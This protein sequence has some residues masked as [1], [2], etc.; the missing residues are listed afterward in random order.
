[1]Y[2]YKRVVKIMRVIK[3]LME[4]RKF[5]LNLILCLFLAKLIT[6]YILIDGGIRDFF[7]L[8]ITSVIFIA[9]FIGFALSKF[10]HKNKMF[11]L[12]YIGLSVLMLADSMYYNYYHQ[13]VS[14]KQLWQIKNV[15]S[16]PE[17][18]FA[19][20]IPLSVFLLIDIPFIYDFFKKFVEKHSK[21]IKEIIYKNIKSRKSIKRMNI[22][23]ALVFLI[24]VVNPLNS[25]LI[26][27]I[28]SVEFFANH[29]KDVYM[30]LTD[31]MISETISAE[32]VL[33][34]VEVIQQDEVSNTLKYHGIGEGK[35]L[36]MVQ[37]E[38]L[39]NFVIGRDY[40]GHT[41][42]PN[43]NKLIEEDSLYF[44]SY[45]SHIGKGN[46]A[47]AEF[48]TLNSLYPDIEREIYTLYEDN[49]FYGL[50]WLL[51]DKGYETVAIHGY[52]GDF[53]NRREAYE[54]QGFEEFYSMEDL[55]Q[56]DWLGMG[57][58]DVSLYNQAI[59]IIKETPQ[60]FFS[61]I[62][63]L[64]NHH[65]YILPDELQTIDLL[66]EHKET[67]FGGYLQT[68]SYTDYAIGQF[69]EQLK[70]ADLYEDSIIV[71]YGDHHG[72]NYGMDDNDKIVSEYLGKPYYYDEMLN[73][74]LIIHIPGSDCSE[75]ISNTGGF[76]DFLP[77]IANIMNLDIP[78]PYILGSDIVNESEG[79]VA[80]TSYLLEGS[81][82][83]N[84]IML[85]ISREGIL[86]GSRAW[87]VNTY[88]SIDPLLLED[89]Y[90]RA[91]TVKQISE[92]VLEQDLIKDYISKNKLE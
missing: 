21:N 66:E 58:S 71:F 17:S 56:T 49:T 88:E 28:N 60:P 68:V 59:D 75:T 32:E 1:M 69:I 67:K 36:I 5:Y 62:I 84:D 65:P 30:A 18:V 87:N 19:T 11:L 86:E 74:P 46:T 23:F 81:F 14:V 2:L 22:I 90:N 76:I 41:L 82:I 57:I 54:G 8:I 3:S 85:E 27:K 24:V 42:T 73:V 70:E 15:A 26:T 64:T 39:Q 16:V 10:K 20:F 51:R 12:I 31:N 89:S 35:N 37:V 38:S 77:T 79:F 47:D 52:K 6:Y 63:T 9:I 29:I 40:N 25:T 7:N 44:D 80:F 33:E 78:H 61:F 48:S 34:T 53:W 91:I 4:N 13:T 55:D 83:H 43:I 92:G 45:Y 50:P 72:L